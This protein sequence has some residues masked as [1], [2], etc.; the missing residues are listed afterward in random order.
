[1]FGFSHK[2]LTNAG[3]RIFLRNF[4]TIFAPGFAPQFLCYFVFQLIG[5]KCV[6]ASDWY[7]EISHGHY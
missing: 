3:G 6:R 5:S 2:I 4:C 7:C 1:M